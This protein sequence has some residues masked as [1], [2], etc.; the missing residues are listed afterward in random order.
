MW[1]QQLP[2][3]RAPPGEVAGLLDGEARSGDERPRS[4]GI[5]AFPN[6]LAY[7]ATHAIGPS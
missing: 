2:E 1:P 6:R 7:R 5:G 4:G 3:Q